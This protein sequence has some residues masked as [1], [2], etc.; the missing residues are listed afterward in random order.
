MVI[1]FSR[2]ECEW[3]L[4]VVKFK[5]KKSTEVKDVL[6]KASQMKFENIILQ[7]KKS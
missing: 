3:L 2:Y 7:I 6:S 1:T 4:S 5:N